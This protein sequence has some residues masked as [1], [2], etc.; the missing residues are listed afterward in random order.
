MQA[1]EF[2]FV[3]KLGG[4]TLKLL[5]PKYFANICC[6]FTNI[7]WVCFSDQTLVR[8]VKNSLSSLVL[9]ISDVPKGSCF[10]P[11]L[12]LTFVNDLP[13]SLTFLVRLYA[14]NYAAYGH[15]E[16]FWPSSSSERP[17]CYAWVVIIIAPSP[18]SHKASLLSV[19]LLWSIFNVPIPPKSCSCS[20]F[21]LSQISHSYYYGRH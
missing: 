18:E 9:V 11:H 15:T 13:N 5:L 4:S 16:S 20:A 1:L 19:F 6:N 10:E 3:F 2:D 12:F 8:L 7:T 14:D 21:L 17:R